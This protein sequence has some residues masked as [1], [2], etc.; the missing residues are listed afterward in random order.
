MAR[1]ERFKEAV[2][3]LPTAEEVRR[4]AEQGWKLVAVEWQRESEAAP[5][6]VAV[7]WRAAPYGLE[8][9]DGGYELVES[10]Q[11]EA[12]LRLILGMVIDDRNTLCEVAAE[13]NRRG[14]RTR[15]GEDW[16][17]SAVFTMLPRLVD[18][19]PK[20]YASPAWA[21]EREAARPT[22]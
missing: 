15:G 3:E 8:T 17:Q 12:A 5:D 20:L 4:R 14:F 18:V 2:A 16:S 22:A 9:P 19:A 1:T 6:D 13:L 10:S 11:E 21:A 7:S